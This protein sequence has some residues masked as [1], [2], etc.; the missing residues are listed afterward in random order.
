VPVCLRHGIGP[1]SLLAAVASALRRQQTPFALIGAGALAV[2][3][4][5]R[6]TRDLDLLIVDARALTDTY[7]REL[8]ATG[9]SV[10]VR[11]GGADDPLAGVVRITRGDESPVDVVVGGSPW[12]GAILERARETRIEDG[13]LPVATPADLILLKL[14]AGGPQDAWDV[15]Q[16]LAD[17]TAD[18]TVTDVEARLTDLPPRCRAFWR[19]LRQAG[20]ESS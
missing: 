16:L 18:S 12:Q 2:H 11:R 4:I 10:A 7:W 20:Q 1:V 3:G 5:P 17:T 6:S 13:R 19:R 8:R 15:A 14:Y 9:A